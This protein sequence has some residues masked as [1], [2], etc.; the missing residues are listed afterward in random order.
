LT[1]LLA[2]ANGKRRRVARLDPDN[3]EARQKIGYAQNFL[4]DPYSTTERFNRL[5][6]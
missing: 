6:T 4:S 5:E 3:A 1:P 2:R